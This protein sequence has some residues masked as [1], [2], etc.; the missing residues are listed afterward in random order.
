MHG[1]VSAAKLSQG[2]SS[3][4]QGL[5]P[6]FLWQLDHTAEAVCLRDLLRKPLNGRYRE[7]RLVPQGL[8]PGFVVRVDVRAEART[9]LRDK[10]NGN[11]QGG[12]VLKPHASPKS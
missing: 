12:G 5:K 4:P 6:Y 8:K 10:S 1:F 2:M 11:D 7:F 9:Y 3:V